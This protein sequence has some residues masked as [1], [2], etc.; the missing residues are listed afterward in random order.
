M[1]VTADTTLIA[2]A[3][4]NARA[5]ARQV[6]QMRSPGALVEIAAG[7]EEAAAQALEALKRIEN[8]QGAATAGGRVPLK[9]GGKVVGEVDADAAQS[10]YVHTD[11]SAIGFSI[12]AKVG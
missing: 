7:T 2:Q 4:G 10:L 5:L 9:L 1:S 11:M 8:Q 12:G 6:K 3:L